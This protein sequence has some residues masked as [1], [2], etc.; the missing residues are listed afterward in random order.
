MYRRQFEV[1][2]MYVPNSRNTLLSKTPSFKA[3]FPGNSLFRL[4]LM[5]GVFFPGQS[6]G[7]VLMTGHSRP[8]QL[9]PPPPVQGWKLLRCGQSQAL[10]QRI[11]QRRKLMSWSQGQE[12]GRQADLGKKLLI[13]SQSQELGRQTDLRRKLFKCS[14]LVKI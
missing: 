6:V 5:S 4:R 7:P 14:Q 10:G 3:C 8:P 11:D 12:L 1:R 2:T 9:K 13:C